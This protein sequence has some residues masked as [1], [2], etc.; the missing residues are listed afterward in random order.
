MDAPAHPGRRSGRHAE[1]P[2]LRRSTKSH[3]AFPLWNVQDKSRLLSVLVRG[4]GGDRIR[5]SNPL[6]VRRHVGQLVKCQLHRRHISTG[7]GNRAE[8]RC[9]VPV[10]HPGRSGRQS[11]QRVV[12]PRQRCRFFIHKHCAE[13]QRRRTQS[14][15]PDFGYRGRGTDHSVLVRRSGLVRRSSHRIQ[16]LLQMRRL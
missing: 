9:E 5:D 14:A 2:S 7:D 8:R 13:Q 15:H 11:V 4:H 6:T 16:D 12:A 1:Q 3:P 10:A